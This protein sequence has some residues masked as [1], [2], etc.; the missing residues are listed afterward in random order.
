MPAPAP[1]NLFKDLGKQIIFFYYGLD[2]LL[3]WSIFGQFSEK[4]ESRFEDV[5]R[6]NITGLKHFGCRLEEGKGLI[7][8]G[9]GAD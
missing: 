3:V 8:R 5:G 7:G 6:R 2:F 9:L 4:A 1:K